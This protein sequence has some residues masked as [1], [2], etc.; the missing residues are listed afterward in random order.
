MLID[1]VDSYKDD[2]FYVVE[3][4]VH[5]NRGKGYFVRSFS[6]QY[7]KQE[8]AINSYE[9]LVNLR[10]SQVR[11]EAGELISISDEENRYWKNPKKESVY[12]DTYWLETVLPPKKVQITVEALPI[13]D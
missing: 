1:L 4:S 2:L 3:A 10:N 12:Q 8:D 5:V 7:A 6:R 13:T 11:N 9:N